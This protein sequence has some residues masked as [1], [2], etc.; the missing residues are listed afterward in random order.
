MTYSVLGE[1]FSMYGHNKEV[2]DAYHITVEELSNLE[3][4]FEGYD[5]YDDQ[6]TEFYKLGAEVY[7]AISNKV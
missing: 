6:E 7:A 2:S 5:F 3:H 4:G 1:G